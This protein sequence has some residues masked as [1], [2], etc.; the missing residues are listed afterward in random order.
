VTID[1][2]TVLPNINPSVLAEQTACD[3]LLVN[4]QLGGSVDASVIGGGSNDTN[5]YTFEWY[6]GVFSLATLPA[7]PDATG[8]TTASNLA[9]GDYTLVVTNDTTQCQ[10][11]AFINL[12]DNPI[13][14]TIDAA[15]TIVDANRCDDPWGSSISVSADAGMTAANGYTFQYALPGHP[16]GTHQRPEARA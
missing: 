11:L 10:N 13:K 14:P 6:T 5:N 12:P 1:D 4:G 2:N 7:S 15:I 8:S 16:D 3:S 9:A